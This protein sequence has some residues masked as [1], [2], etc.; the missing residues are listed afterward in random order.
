MIEVVQ[1]VKFAMHSLH[2]AWNVVVVVLA[3]HIYGRWNLESSKFLFVC[4]CVMQQ[5]KMLVA[6]SNHATNDADWTK[7][8][9]VK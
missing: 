2:Y 7:A 1:A 9:G 4:V 8:V 3:S 6:S 5:L